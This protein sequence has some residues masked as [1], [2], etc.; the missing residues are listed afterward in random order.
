MKRSSHSRKFST[1][2]EK[3][4][5]PHTTFSIRLEYREVLALCTPKPNTNGSCYCRW[6]EKLHTMYNDCFKI[7][8]ITCFV[9]L[10]SCDFSHSDDVNDEQSLLNAVP[11]REKIQ[12]VATFIRNVEKLFTDFGY[13]VQ[14][15]RIATNPFGEWLLNNDDT[16]TTFMGTNTMLGRLHILDKI[17]SIYGINFCSLGPAI[18]ESQVRDCILPIILSSEKFSTSATLSSTDVMMANQCAK[19]IKQIANLTMDGLG[20]F[21]FCV[22]ASAVA[23]IPF[24]P[25]AKAAASTPD[26]SRNSNRVCTFSIGLENGV[27]TNLLLQKCSSIENIPTVFKSCMVDALTPL[28]NL[29]EQIGNDKYEFVGIDTSLNPSLSIDGSIAK[30]IECLEEVESFGSP[31]TL[32][33]ASIITQTL[34]SLPGIKHCGY[35]G[36]ML[37]VC[38]DQR[39]CELADTKQLRI[40]DLLSISQVCGVG[41]DTVP[42]PGDCTEKELASVLLDVAGLA[43]RWNK[44]LSCRVFPVPSKAVGDCTNFDSPYMVN[45]RVLSLSSRTG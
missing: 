8:T 32:A 26:I 36:I 4:L 13:S 37:P 23:Y 21:R 41:I 43:H 39:L 22:A 28:Q 12:N 18:T 33:A 25:I 6:C 30:A 16:I 14:T 24:F 29:C 17:L 5:L 42:I 1:I 40:S 45:A 19:T 9:T 20:N 31:G 15:V 10:Q 35:S 44:S 27:L 3:M 34:Q 2:R 7:R 11:L 38:E